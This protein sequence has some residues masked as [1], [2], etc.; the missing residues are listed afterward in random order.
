MVSL[1]TIVLMCSFDCLPSFGFRSTRYGANAAGQTTSIIATS[2]ED[3]CAENARAS[4]EYDWSE[5]A[6]CGVT[7]TL[8]PV[9]LVNRLASAVSRLFPSPTESP[10]N[11]M[12][13]PPYFFLIAAAFLTRGGL[14]VAAV[15]CAC[16]G[17]L[18]AAATLKEAMSASTP[19]PPARTSSLRCFTPPL[20][21]RRPRTAVV[22]QERYSFQSDKDA[23]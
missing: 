6:G 23:S 11:V 15:R 5:A 19:T 7:F 2:I 13:W 8:M 12:L 4:C 3:E 9:S 10:T 14:I 20:L 17:L 21:S 18:L 16:V 1:V 22:D